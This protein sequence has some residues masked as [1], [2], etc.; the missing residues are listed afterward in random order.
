M[1]PDEHLVIV[2]GGFSGTLLAINLLRHDGPRAT[3]LERRRSQLGRGVAYSAAHPSHL[4]NVRA[5]GMSAF[6]D[7]PEHF[8][9]WVAARGEGA[10]QDFVARTL[11]GA[12]LRETLATVRRGR[13]DR[14]A[15]VAGEAIDLRTGSERAVLLADGSTIA[16]DAVVLATGNLPP[17]AP[18][19]IDPDA[20]SPRWYV[21][22]PWRAD[23]AE[24]V[25]E[26]DT[27]VL[28]GTGLTAI[29]AALQLDAAGFAGRIIALSRR[30]LSP[31]RHR[32]G[33]APTKGLANPPAEPLS[34]LVAA[35]R[36]DAAE[37][38]WRAAVDAY[39]PVTQRLWAASDAVVRARFLRHLR[40]F[41]DVHRHRLAPAVAARIDQMVAAG[42]LRFVAGK[43]QGCVADGAALRLSWRP[44]RGEQVMTTIAARV[45]NCTGPQGDLTR[46]TEPLLRVLRERGAIRPDPLRLG[47]EVDTRSRVVARDGSADDS[48]YCIGP[49]TRGGLWEVVAVPDLRRH[50]WDLARRLANANWVGGEGL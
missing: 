39:R 35:T 29:D 15:L 50:A 32:D 36:A 5:A 28:L 9:R 25:G 40:P 27:V 12:Y 30:G 17:H 21:G 4:L 48:L 43:V 26:G 1:S 22:D 42:R 45:V 46:T 3:L 7:E 10:G 13:E 20:L 49:M 6:P 8:A 34:R 41:W 19:G 23:L 11:Y 47:L 16:A 33:L 18:P 31:R 44:R 24:G 14:L 38:G 37:V 2:G